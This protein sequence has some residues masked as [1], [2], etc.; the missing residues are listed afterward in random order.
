MRGR[1]IFQFRA[2][3]ERVDTDAIRTAGDYDDDFREV[4]KVDGDG[5]GIGETQRV[6]R[7]A[8]TVPCQ[9]EPDSWETLRAHAL[10]LDP[11]VDVTL[12]F[13]FRDLEAQGLVTPEGKAL[14]HVGDRL[15][16]INDRQGALVHEVTYPPG[17]Y[18]VDAT[19]ASY[20]LN[21][22]LPRR[23]LLLVRFQERRAGM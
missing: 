1:L 6:Y 16:R 4:V 5:D 11:E 23:N 2:E 15:R 9:V 12:V 7:A 17:L 18:V 14:I 8:D 10:G 20:G 19:D 13:H 21:M 22:A 3:V